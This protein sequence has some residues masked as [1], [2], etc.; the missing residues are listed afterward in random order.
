MDQE[1]TMARAVGSKSSPQSGRKSW[2][3]IADE[4]KRAT[5]T[6]EVYR[7]EPGPDVSAET[8]HSLAGV[9]SVK[10]PIPAWDI[11]DEEQGVE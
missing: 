2:L 6:V 1:A 8:L 4:F 11:F 9:I 5:G 3:E 10:G 7:H